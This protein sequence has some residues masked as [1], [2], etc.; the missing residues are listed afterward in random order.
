M[1]HL[2]SETSPSDNQGMSSSKD[3]SNDNNKLIPVKSESKDGDSNNQ[4]EDLR[5]ENENLFENRPAIIV[6]DQ[7]SNGDNGDF[8]KNSAFNGIHHSEEELITGDDDDSDDDLEA[9]GDIWSMMKSSESSNNNSSD[10]NNNTGGMNHHLF[11]DFQSPLHDYLNSVGNNFDRIK[12]SELLKMDDLI[13]EIK[14]SDEES[15]LIQYLSRRN[16]LEDLIKYYL[17]G[18]APP[19]TSVSAQTVVERNDK[20]NL[21][22]KNLEEPSS[23]QSC[24]SDEAAEYEKSGYTVTDEISEHNDAVENDNDDIFLKIRCPYMVTQIICCSINPIL[25]NFVLGEEQHDLSDNSEIS[26]VELLFDSMIPQISMDNTKS[27][28]MMTDRAAGYFDQIIATL[29]EFDAANM[30]RIISK[31]SMRTTE[32]STSEATL[33]FLVRLLPHVHCFAISRLIYKLLNVTIV[34]TYNGGLDVTNDSDNVD[35]AG[36]GCV[37]NCDGCSYAINEEG[38][39]RIPR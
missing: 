30:D 37:G 7:T 10:N 13:Q 38:L 25:K 8:N 24:P 35:G 34:N 39:A 9:D 29:F 19:P 21:N 36:D 6:M 3:D 22:V 20:Q 11:D 31:M 17:I 28:G 15:V 12:S 26:L 32:Q 23:I 14:C 1:I 5:S 27:H 2:I 16:V 33:S 18:K 4:E